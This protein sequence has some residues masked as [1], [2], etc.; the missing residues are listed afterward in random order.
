MAGPSKARSPGPAASLPTFTRAMSPALLGTAIKASTNTARERVAPSALAKSWTEVLD[1]IPSAYKE[2]LHKSFKDLHSRALKFHNCEAAYEKLHAGQNDAKPPPPVQG[3]HEPHWQV[4][5]EFRDSEKG[6]SRLQDIAAAHQNYVTL[7]W[8]AGLELKGAELAF[9]QN[10][11][12]TESWW[13]PILA[14][15]DDVYNKMDRRGPR[16]IPAVEGQEMTVV[17][18]ES[19]ILIQEHKDFVEGLPNLCLRVFA[20]KK[21]RVVADANK[22][23]RKAVLKDAADVDMANGTNT[24]SNVVKAMVQAE[25]RKFLS[26]NPQQTK[27]TPPSKG[28]KVKAPKLF[29]C[30]HKGKTGHTDPKT[31]LAAPLH[32]G[33]KQK[34]RNQGGKNKGKGKQ[35]ESSKQSK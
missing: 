27:G 30:K 23:R 29:V 3:L 9:H 14:I 25:V 6:T 26:K 17:Y 21:A 12:L 32:Y 19:A 24:D 8:E 18:K 10:R 35:G 16:V 7:A 13:P 4:T 11:V 31:G 20:I 15:A 1:C 2:A 34:Q 33:P 5:K 28:A 22:L